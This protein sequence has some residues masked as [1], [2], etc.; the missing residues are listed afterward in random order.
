MMNTAK[1]LSFFVLVI[2]TLLMATS[3]SVAQSVLLVNATAHLG[4]GKAIEKSIVGIENGIIKQVFNAKVVDAALLKYDTVI[5][6]SGKHIYPGFIAADAVLGLTEVEAV[7]ATN[8]FKEVGAFNPHIRSLVAYNA[9]SKV[10]A[11]VKTNGVLLAQ[12]TPRGGV[13]SGTSSIVKLEAWNWEDAVFRTDD[14]IHLNW[15]RPINE[16]HEKAKEMKVKRAAILQELEQFFSA[17]EAYGKAGYQYDRNQKYEAMRGLF[18]GSKTLFVHVDF[19]REITEAVYF[20]RAYQLKK[21]VIVGGYDAWRI[22]ELLK[23]NHVSVVVRRV[24]SLPIREDD[25][26]DLSFRVPAL[27]YEAGVSFCLG[28]AGGMEAMQTRN[29]PFYA[30]TAV[31]Y[32]LPYE[33]AVKAITLGAATILGIA[34]KVGTLEEGKAAT[35]IVS[36]GD[37][38]DA[39]SNRIE[40]AWIDG[41]RIDLDNHQKALYR[42][43]QH[44][45]QQKKQVK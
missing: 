30:G 5:D 4:N 2:Y 14:G 15:P 8:D 45:Y 9:E 19:V 25:P 34:N 28:N 18:D 1:P 40:M 6:L 3:T 23:D 24:H 26:V 35:L 10:T 7:R 12:I 39:R 36:A 44:K 41:Q 20:A 38:L 21:I 17:A 32:G 42:R 13:L 22:P 16:A 37:A 33:E 11:T 29:L 31:A 27:L 43:Y